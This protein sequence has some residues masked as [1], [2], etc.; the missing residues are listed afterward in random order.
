MLDNQQLIEELND[1]KDE[2]G[3]MSADFNKQMNKMIKIVGAKLESKKN[4]E[5]QAIF[6]LNFDNY[7]HSLSGSNEKRGLK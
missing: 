3:R 1:L 4:W 2:I 5:A 6:M 7:K